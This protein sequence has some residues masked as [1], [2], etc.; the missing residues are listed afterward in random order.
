MTILHTVTE[1]LISGPDKTPAN[2]NPN[3]PQTSRTL[4]SFALFIL[5]CATLAPAVL[6]Y[7]LRLLHFHQNELFVPLS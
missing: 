1:Y 5:E 2:S 3:L 4:L 7:F 6:N